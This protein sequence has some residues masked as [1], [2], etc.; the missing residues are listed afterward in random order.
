MEDKRD[1]LCIFRRV[2]FHESNVLIFL[3][4]GKFEYENDKWTVMD[5]DGVKRSTNGTWQFANTFINIEDGMII[6]AAQ[7]V[8]EASFIELL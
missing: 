6:K 5:G 1:R 3:L 4:L 7:L 8:L 2:R